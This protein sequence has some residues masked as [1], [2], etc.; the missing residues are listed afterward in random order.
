MAAKSNPV[1]VTETSPLPEQDDPPKRPGRKFKFTD[2]KELRA[3]I[4]NYFKSRDQHTEKQLM[5]V[6]KD[7][8]G[9]P[10]YEAVEVLVEAKPYGVAGL[11]VA[12]DTNRTTLLEY[13]DEDH[14]TEEIS[15]EVR[16][17]L[18][19]T[20]RWAKAAI[21]ANVEEFAT[22]PAN[23][24]AKGS[25]FS[26]TN[27][28]SSKPTAGWA[29]KQEVDHTTKG[30]KIPVPQVYLPQDLPRDAVQA[31]PATANEPQA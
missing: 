8:N 30:D 6:G 18:I 25:I 27:N 17:E 12:L 3:K 29:E 14:Y 23:K 22:D 15:P 26:L 5:E 9:L 31:A 13:E 28:F 10:R 7:K 1:G 16:D 19:N 20:I 21:E 11:A 2:P 24:N 4:E